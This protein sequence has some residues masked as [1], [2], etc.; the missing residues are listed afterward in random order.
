M[1]TRPIRSARR[2]LAL[3]HQNL[4]DLAAWRRDLD[5]A[6]PFFRGALTRTE[7]LARRDPGSVMVHRD[8][9]I[10]LRRLVDLEDLAGRY[11]AAADWSEQMLKV[12][13]AQGAPAYPERGADE[14]EARLL[15]DVYRLADRCIDDPA[16]ARSQPPKVARGLLNVRAVRLARTGRGAEAVE[17]ARELLAL[18]DAPLAASYAARACTIAA[19]APGRSRPED[20][21]ECIK[22]AVLALRRAIANG[23]VSAPLLP[24]DPEFA[25]LRDDPDFIALT[26]PPMDRPEPEG[27]G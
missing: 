13:T 18:T 27:T 17:A 21:A 15:R 16:L 10:V 11:A 6:R 3:A 25:A 26:R 8:R 1:P 5:T 4:G 14:A 2:C 22:T 20:R 9:L 7:E 24:F 12:A 19:A 23:T